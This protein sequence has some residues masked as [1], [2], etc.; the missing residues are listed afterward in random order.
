[1][2]ARPTSTTPVWLTIVLSRRVLG[3]LLGHHQYQC[4][5]AVRTKKTEQAVP[6]GATRTSAVD[7]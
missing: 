1:M 4:I 2:S 3:Y 7:D 6:I 5:S